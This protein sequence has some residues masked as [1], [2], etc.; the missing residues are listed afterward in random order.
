VDKQFKPLNS[1]EVLSVNKSA[2][3]VIG[4]GTFRVQEFMNTLREQMIQHGFGS[5]SSDKAQ[6]FSEEG[7]ECEVL[8]FGSNGWEKGSVRLYLE[9]SP[10]QPVSSP[11]P[12]PA[13]TVVSAPVPPKSSQP[14]SPPV[15][16]EIIVETEATAAAT[17]ALE[18]AQEEENLSFNDD[19]EVES[20]LDFEES[21]VEEMSIPSEDLGADFGSDLEDEGLGFDDS[22]E[23]ETPAADSFEEGLGDD[24]GFDFGDDDLGGEDLGSDL[25]GDDFGLGGDD[26]GLGEDDFESS[27]NTDGEGLGIGDVFGTDDDS[28]DLNLG[29]DAMDDVWGEMEDL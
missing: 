5:V 7:I 1:G 18:V 4:H 12:T 24:N 2:Q 14:I 11:P 21:S 27:H 19:F 20:G 26:F 28:L 9:F 10:D 8:Q 3:F 23:D 16:E 29:D 15:M 22:F 17:A 6:W 25:G 13:P